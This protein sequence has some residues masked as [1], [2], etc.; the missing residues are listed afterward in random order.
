MVD[1]LACFKTS[2]ELMSLGKLYMILAARQR[3][4]SKELKLSKLQH[5]PHTTRPYHYRYSYGM[6]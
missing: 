1:H 6:P 4:L 3:N 5:H 2:A